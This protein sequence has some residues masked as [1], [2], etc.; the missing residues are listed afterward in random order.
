MVLRRIGGFL[1]IND[2]SD[3]C[4]HLIKIYA[5]TWLSDVDSYQD[6]TL[7]TATGRTIRVPYS[8]AEVRRLLGLYPEAHMESSMSS[9]EIRDG[10]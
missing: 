8:L 1:E 10:I 2:S 6:A 4:L 3:E 7:I 5:I 9:V